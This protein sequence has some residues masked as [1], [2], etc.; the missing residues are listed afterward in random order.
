MRYT[1]MGITGPAD[2]RRRS[3]E[4]WPSRACR[5]WLVKSGLSQTQSTGFLRTASNLA[6]G[7]PSAGW[8][9]YCQ[10]A[11]AGK[12]MRMLSTLEPGV[13]KPNWVP[14]SSTRLNST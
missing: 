14:R 3:G 5:D 10:E 6:S 8:W 2:P 9:L 1:E 7:E 13:C 4:V 12:D 11:V